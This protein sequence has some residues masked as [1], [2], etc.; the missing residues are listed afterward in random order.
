MRSFQV[1]IP[2]NT[3]DRSRLHGK[4]RRKGAKV[5]HS[6]RESRGFWHNSCFLDG[7]YPPNSIR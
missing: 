2:K 5:S 6:K 4:R 1:T 3:R 7:N